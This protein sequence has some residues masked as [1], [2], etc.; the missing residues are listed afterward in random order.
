MTDIKSIPE[1]IDFFASNPDQALAL[2]KLYTVISQSVPSDRYEML[3]LVAETSDNIASV[4]NTGVRVWEQGKTSKKSIKLGIC[5]L[6][7]PA[8]PI[9]NVIKEQLYEK[10]ITLDD[11][12]KVISSPHPEMGEA[13]KFRYFNTRIEMEVMISYCL[14]N[15]IKKLGICSPLFHQPRVYMTALCALNKLNASQQLS[16][17]SVV[18]ERLNWNEMVLHSQGVVKELRY[19]LL[20]EEMLRVFKYGLTKEL[21]SPDEALEYLLGHCK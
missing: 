15:K 18:G 3:Y 13:G 19:N 5:G 16:I 2:A 6:E 4:V 12:V 21:A 14:E 9:P 11:V 8:A 7:H 17:Y 1:V 20:N 10:G